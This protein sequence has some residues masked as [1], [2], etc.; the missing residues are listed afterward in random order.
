MSSDS[1]NDSSLKTESKFSHMTSYSM[2]VAKSQILK[3]LLLDLHSNSHT[4][5]LFYFII[6]NKVQIAFGYSNT[7]TSRHFKEL[8]NNQNIFP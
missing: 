6:A 1:N 5:E 8:E 4:T 2:S 7:H 3:Q